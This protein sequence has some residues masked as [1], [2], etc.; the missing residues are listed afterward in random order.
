MSLMGKLLGG[1]GGSL[2]AGG[3]TEGTAMMKEAKA[4]D[5]AT[6]NNL[7]KSMGDKFNTFAANKANA[8][9]KLT[10]LASV[11][12]I[13][14]ELDPDA[15]FGYSSKNMT[16]LV[17]SLEAIGGEGKAIETYM[18]Q[19]KDDT[20]S[21]IPQIEET[22]GSD[23]ALLHFF[24]SVNWNFCSFPSHQKSVVKGGERIRE[25]PRED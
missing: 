24:R 11:G 19:K 3:A 2:V 6:L 18:A 12:S 1:V 21:L 9:K 16:D 7:L 17:R 22:D 20:Y 15:F 25:L 10:R 13:L 5:K 8:S 4:E 23:H 14:Q